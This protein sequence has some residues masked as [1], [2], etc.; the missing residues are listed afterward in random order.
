MG[1]TFV[2]AVLLFGGLG[3]LVDG[4]LHTRPLFAIAGGLLGGTAWFLNLYYRVRREVEAG[5]HKQ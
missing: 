3:W 1:F 5:K 2:I 4:W